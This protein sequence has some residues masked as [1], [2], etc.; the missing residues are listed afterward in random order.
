MKAN[1][2]MQG[3]VHISGV[4]NDEEFSAHGEASGNPQTGEYR[5]ELRYSSIPKGWHPFLYTDPKVGLLFLREEEQGRNLL[6]L[7]RGIYTAST[8]IDLGEGN[9][10]RNNAV[11][12][13]VDANR[14]V[15]SYAMYGTSRIEALIGMDYLEET[16]LPMGPGRIAAL[17]IARWSTADGGKI[18]AIL[19]TR[20]TFDVQH[21]LDRPQIRRIEVQP[22]LQANTFTARFTGSARSLPRLIEEGG[23]YIG[24]LIG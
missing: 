16:M 10:L 18:D 14:F 9:L 17:A 20:Y 5:L 22:D 4:I 6:T 11:I 12:R 23:P 7:A 19:S 13:M 8:T 15:A 3:E 24:H 21:R 2:D 1:S